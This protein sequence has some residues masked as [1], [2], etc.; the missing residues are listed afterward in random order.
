MTLRRTLP[1]RYGENPHQ[2]AA[3][4]AIVGADPASGPLVAGAEPLQGKPLSYNNL[5]D[6]S[7]AAAVARDLH[8]PAVVIVKH[9]N[10][11]G[12]AEADDL[13]TAWER[14]LE[15]D[16]IS[17]FGGVVAVRGVV[18]RELAEKLR[19]LFLEV[20]VAEGFDAEARGIFGFEARSTLARGS[21]HHLRPAVVA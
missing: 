5:L 6:A 11:C 10:P 19:S 9:G 13:V 14:A 12:A 4:Y 21:D 18:D 15:A 16:P 2:E 20:V 7:A 1:L 17:A 3:L 8:G